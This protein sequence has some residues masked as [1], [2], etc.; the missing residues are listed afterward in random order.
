[1]TKLFYRILYILTL[2]LVLP[3]VLILMAIGGSCRLTKPVIKP[4]SRAI[5]HVVR[6]LAWL[7]PKIKEPTACDYSD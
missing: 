5:A 2:C 1:M 7:K 6:W 3:P 4:M